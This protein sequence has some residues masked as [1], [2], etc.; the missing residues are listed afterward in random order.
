MSCPAAGVDLCK[1]W[2][3][4]R[5]RLGTEQAQAELRSEF[6]QII[7]AGLE[8]GFPGE[9]MAEVQE[10]VRKRVVELS[11]QQRRE[12]GPK[13]RIPPQDL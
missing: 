6:E 9:A 12:P 7:A 8:R 5:C 13:A 3:R 2:R 11:S 10:A 1:A 4:L